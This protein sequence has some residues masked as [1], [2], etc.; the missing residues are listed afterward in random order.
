M[1]KYSDALSN[2]L[3]V[4][5]QVS[6]FQRVR[7]EEIMK[8][9][10]QDASENIVEYYEYYKTKEHW[11]N[12]KYYVILDKDC[13]DGR[14]VA[15]HFL[16]H[17]LWN[18]RIIRRDLEKLHDWCVLQEIKDKIVGEEFEALELYPARS[19]LMDEG[20]CYHLWILAPKNEGESPPKIPV[21]HWRNGGALLILQ[22]FYEKMDS[23]NN[24]RNLMRNIP[25]S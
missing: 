23:E 6:S 12:D 15:T 2:R 5:R 25:I 24:N 21:G 16:C 14:F 13:D 10:P 18:M 19:Q 22:Q 9:P 8:P 3:R 20:N 1:G 11:V 7:A 4:N 17:P